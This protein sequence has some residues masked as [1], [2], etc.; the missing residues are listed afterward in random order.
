MQTLSPSAIAGPYR[1]APDAPPTDPMRGIWLALAV[2]VPFWA[3]LVALV[4]R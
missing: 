2:V 1:P 3:G 4:I